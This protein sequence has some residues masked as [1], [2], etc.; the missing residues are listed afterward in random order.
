MVQVQVQSKISPTVMEGNSMI[1]QEDRLPDAFWSDK[2]LHQMAVAVLEIDRHSEEPTN[3]VLYRLHKGGIDTGLVLIAAVKSVIDGQDAINRLWAEVGITAEL[4]KFSDESPLSQVRVEAMYLL[5]QKYRYIG[6][7]KLPGHDKV[8][9]YC[10][11][12]DKLVQNQG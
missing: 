4:G 11:W 3:A 8:Y 12:F 9:K 7:N 1:E 10:S 6:K 2:E 5:L